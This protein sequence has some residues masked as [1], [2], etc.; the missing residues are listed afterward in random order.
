MFA[1]VAKVGSMAGW[2][3]EHLQTWVD[4][5]LVTE[6]QAEGIRSFEAATPGG[7]RRVVAAEAVGYVGAALALGALALLLGEWWGQLTG[8][9]RVALACAATFLVATAAVVVGRASAE[10]LRRLT[11]VLAATS[12][13]GAGWVAYLVAA[14]IVRLGDADVAATVAVTVWIVALGVFLARPRPLGQLVLLAATAALVGAALARPAITPSP[15]W[16]GVAYWGLGVV[17]LLLGLGGRLA[18]RGVAVIAGAVVAVLSLQVASFGEARTWLLMLGVATAVGLVALSL[19]GGEPGALAVGSVATF[20]FVPQVTF[21]VFGDAIGAPATL[22][23]AGI[24]L[25][26][27]AVVISRLR[28]GADD[29]G[30]GPGP[31]RSE[32]G[33]PDGAPEPDRSGAA[34]PGHHRPSEAP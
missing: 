18:H 13:V 7:D 2:L 24:L 1:D 26:V 11:S 4:A 12:V 34:G 20:A 6:V 14:D 27:T 30:G 8:A 22:L 17:W 32:D 25:V 10:P 28:R 29:A 16:V 15:A 21:E 19:S 23:V 5:G 3:D 9:G 31:P 33:D